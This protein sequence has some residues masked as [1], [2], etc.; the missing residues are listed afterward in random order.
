MLQGNQILCGR[1]LPDK[2]LKSVK[3]I[4][5]KT[6]NKKAFTEDANPPLVNRMGGSPCTVRSKLNK[7]ENVRAGRGGPS[8][9]KC[10]ALS[11]KV[12]W[13]NPVNT[14]RQTRLKLLLSYKF[15]I[16]LP[17]CQD[18]KM[19]GLS[20]KIFCPEVPSCGVPPISL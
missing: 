14:D 10:N 3:N 5:I 18:W 13:D 9:V 2:H 1:F 6:L 20:S 16:E 7:F 19:L 11:L 15:D 8:M 17:S 12:T 4:K